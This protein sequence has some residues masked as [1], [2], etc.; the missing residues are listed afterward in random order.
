LKDK[1]YFTMADGSK[2]TD[3]QNQDPSKKKKVKSETKPGKKR[4]SA[5]VKEKPKAD[6]K[7]AGGKAAGGKKEV[8][9]PK[10]VGKKDSEDDL[11]IDGDSQSASEV[12]EGSD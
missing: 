11:D 5:L 6:A 4:E 10:S 9:K 2:S 1:G 7:S 8:A 12:L 3:A